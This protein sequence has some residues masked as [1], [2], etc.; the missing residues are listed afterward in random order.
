MVDS[1]VLMT[2]LK[3]NKYEVEH[4]SEKE[5]SS[6]VIINTCGFIDNARQESIDT[7]LKYVDAKQH[8]KVDKVYVTGCLSQ[9]YRPELEKEIPEVDGYFGTRDELPRLTKNLES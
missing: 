2:Q 1:E 9:R 3:A 4:E 5:D 7:I 6:I 8:G